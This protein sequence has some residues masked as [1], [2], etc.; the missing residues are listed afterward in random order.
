MALE[1]D[2][3]CWIGR[4]MV[5]RQSLSSNEATTQVGLQLEFVG[6]TRIGP[7]NPLKY[8]KDNIPGYRPLRD[9][10]DTSAAP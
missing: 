5:R 3:G 6:F 4:V 8:L 9:D 1:Y 10:G 7:H 2:S